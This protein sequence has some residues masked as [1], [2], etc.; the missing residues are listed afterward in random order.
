MPPEPSAA[1]EDNGTGSRAPSG[2]LDPRDH[3]GVVDVSLIRRHD[4]LPLEDDSRRR[5]KRRLA[6]VLGCVA[7]TATLVDAAEGSPEELEALVEAAEVLLEHLGRAPS[8]RSIGGPRASSGWQSALT[9]RSPI[10]GQSN[11]VAAPLYLDGIDADG[12]HAHA[13]YGYRHEGPIESAHGGV[14]AGAFDEMV[15]IAQAISGLA[16]VTGTLTVRMR[17]PTPLH[18]RIGY[19]AG[20]DRVEGRKVFVWARSLAD[21]EVCAEAEAIMIV[22]REGS[23]A[24]KYDW[25]ARTSS[26]AETADE[27]GAS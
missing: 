12:L 15:G 23:L 25:T 17:R 7:E 16:G 21:G 26:E 14:I 9:D 20:V 6:E 2:A 13:T 24:P 5:L 4:E 3:Y 8:L 18:R 22:P 10:S 27:P 11:P 1:P 19:E